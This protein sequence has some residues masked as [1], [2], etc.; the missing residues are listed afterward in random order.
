MVDGR[1]LQAG[2]EGFLRGF[3]LTSEL[4][5]QRRA[6]ALQ[7]RGIRLQEA[8]FREDRLAAQRKAQLDAQKLVTTDIKELRTL[9]TET[10]KS[11]PQAAQRLVEALSAP[12]QI[13]M[14]QLDALSGRASQA[15]LQLGSDVIRRD[16]ENLVAGG[17]TPEERGAQAAS[18]TLAQIDALAADPG[19]SRRDALESQGVIPSQAASVQQ[20]R[21]GDRV[22]NV[23]VDR[24][25]NI[26]REL[27]SGPA[28]A[29]R[30]PRPPQPATFLFP[31]GKTVGID[32]TAPGASE[33]VSS[34]QSRGGRRISQGVT[35]GSTT[36]LTGVTAENVEEARGALDD[37][38]TTLD[39]IQN[40]TQAIKD[41]PEA[42]G[43]TGGAV[44]TVGGLLQQFA[45]GR[46]ALDAVGVD[47]AKATDVRT[48]ARTLTASLLETITGE[49]SG[50]FTDTERR[51]AERALRT[52]EVTASVEQIEAAMGT[53]QELFVANRNRNVNTLLEASTAD[54][55]T[56]EGVDAFGDILVSNGFTFDQA[57]EEIQR[58]QRERGLSLQ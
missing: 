38:N 16:L 21:R 54:L 11:S 29:P 6:E 4:Q 39:Q 14:S 40:L 41:N 52:L 45:I 49:E 48:R 10:A 31:D 51:I 36:Q 26:V 19:V 55:S 12:G 27:G 5:Q 46:A 32:L 9:V 2:T 15:G 58:I 23:A 30:Q 33:Q 8:Q 7:L 56:D 25:G 43:L 44:E 35:A 20:I 37:V 42:T 24:N 3:A 34:I 18:E 47:P 13:G 57:I 17:V 53:V 1:A 50:R 28:F 22:V